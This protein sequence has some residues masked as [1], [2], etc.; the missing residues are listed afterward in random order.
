MTSLDPLEP[1][2]GIAAFVCALA[3]FLGAALDG[4]DVTAPVSAPIVGSAR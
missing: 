3:V 4:P 2:A 1:L